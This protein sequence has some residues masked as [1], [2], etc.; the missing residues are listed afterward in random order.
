MNVCQ[1]VALI[2][3]LSFKIF[4]FIYIQKKKK[5]T[6]E[7]NQLK[8][9]IHERFNQTH[10]TVLYFPSSA[11]F[12]LSQQFI[13]PMFG[14]W[15]PQTCMP[16]LCWMLLCWREGEKGSDVYSTYPWHPAIRCFCIKREGGD[17]RC[18]CPL[19]DWYLLFKQLKE[20]DSDKESE[21]VELFSA[22]VL[23]RRQT[24]GCRRNLMF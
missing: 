21:T 10:R 24:D 23:N 6:N 3:T 14:I 15:Q 20:R 5:R 11:Y 8:W 4:S 12:F 17:E 7:C 16:Q 19:S 18:Q 9:I 2:Q 13:L 22:V 1:Q